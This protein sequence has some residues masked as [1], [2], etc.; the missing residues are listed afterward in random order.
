MKIEYKKGLYNLGFIVGIATALVLAA[1]IIGIA[2]AFINAPSYV[3]GSPEV[4]KEAEAR[5]PIFTRL[6][7]IIFTPRY[8]EPHR[9]HFY[10]D[11][12]LL[13][14]LVFG[15]ALIALSYVLIPIGIIYFLRKKKDMVFINIFWLY[16]SFIVLCGM[17]HVMMIMVFWYPVY[18]LEAA[19]LWVTG[20]VSIATF[21]S[22]I[23]II[24]PSIQL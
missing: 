15:N 1:I 4:I 22:F 8:F 10:G 6:V 3:Q 16:G 18:W 5:M 7:Q 2:F 14:W 23:L 20:L 13:W 21:F 12:D 11:G 24:P 19:V 9:V 17:T